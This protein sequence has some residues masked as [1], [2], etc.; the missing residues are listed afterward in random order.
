VE[1]CGCDVNVLSDSLQTPIHIACQ[2]D[3]VEMALYLI[4]ARAKLELQDIN[5][6]TPMDVCTSHR[7]KDLIAR[8]IRRSQEE[9]NA[10]LV[11]AGPIILVN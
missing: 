7:M 9:Q 4:G 3:N 10:I 11:S 8:H 5:G 6:R 1:R 2:D